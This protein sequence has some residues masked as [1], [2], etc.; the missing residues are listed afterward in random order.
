MQRRLELAGFNHE[1]LER[2]FHECIARRI[3][4]LEE[5]FEHDDDWA[6]KRSTRAAIL[7]SSGLQVF[8]SS[9]LTDWLRCLK[10]AFDDGITSWRWDECK[11]NYADPLL[12]IFFESE[13]FWDEGTFHDTGFP[14]QTLE[15]MAVA[16]LEILPTEA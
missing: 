11:Q 7:R 4:I 8:R 5:P 12:E 14:C 6:K 1:T 2:E 3:E 10:T 16:M 9:G 13:A 15:S